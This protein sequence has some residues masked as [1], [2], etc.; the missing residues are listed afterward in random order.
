MKKSFL[1]LLPYFPY[2][3]ITGGNVRIYNLI[4]Y[5]SN[6][7]DINLLSFTDQEIKNSYISHLENFC[8]KVIVVKRKIYEGNLPL[9]FQH[10]YT[11]EMV[12]ELKKF[13]KDKFDFIQIDFL[14]MGYYAKLL[15]ELT[16]IPVFY[17]EHDVS[18]F[19]FEKCFHNR[20]LPD[21]ERYIEWLKMHKIIKEIYPLF[22]LITTVS[23][24]DSE[25]LKKLFP[26]LKIYPAPTGTDCNH[27]KFRRERDNNDLIYVG[28]YVHYPNVD[29]VNFIL[30]K[31]F[32]FLKKEYDLKLY[33]V[34]SGGKKVFNNI[35]S[36]N[37]V[38]TGTV[39]DILPY[40]HKTGIFLAP[41]RIGIGIRGK[42]LEAMASGTPV[43]TSPV[44]AKGIN[45]MDKEH[46]LVA[47]K[48]H[49]YLK[50]IQLLINDRKLKEEII[51]R[52][53]KFVEE[54]YNW[55]KIAKQL[56]E[57]YTKTLE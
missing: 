1:W 36:E 42:I 25:I 39:P 13:L 47:E 3:A 10:Y 26:N 31:I 2:P 18:S 17:S 16:S 23:H 43:I 40:L 45:A 48:P 50:S 34:G 14:I 28:H 46:L 24:N 52:A 5:L 56:I 51:I 53:R 11:P 32:P 54:N 35:N 22:D 6:Y 20:H 19:F 15:K 38:I 21:K 49:D 27:Y 33:I 44:G 30:N 12:R 37:I 29:S 9:I 8:K 4:K 55:D 7:Y 57:I 41:I